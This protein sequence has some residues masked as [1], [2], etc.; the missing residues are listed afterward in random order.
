M[1]V[2]PGFPSL[3]YSPFVIHKESSCYN[4]QRADAGAFATATSGGKGVR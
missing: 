3:V 2:S 4:E 1:T